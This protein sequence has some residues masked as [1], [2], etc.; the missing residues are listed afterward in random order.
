MTLPTRDGKEVAIKT[1]D[2]NGIGHSP[3][4]DRSTACTVYKN[5]GDKI[6]IAAPIRDVKSII[7]KGTP[8][9]KQ[10]QL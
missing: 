7:R 5:N 3:L 9:A 6:R 10:N 2:I 1:A 8:A 4:Q